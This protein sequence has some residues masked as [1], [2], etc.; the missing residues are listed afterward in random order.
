MSRNRLLTIVL[1]ASSFAFL[2]RDVIVKLVHDWGIDENYSHGFLVVPLVVYIL[3]R[4][5]DHLA[6]SPTRPSMAG[7]VLIAGSVAMLV[8]GRLGAELYLTRLAML[9]TLAGIVVLLWGFGRLRQLSFEFLLLFLAIPI[10]A[11]IFNQI[12]FPLQLV[13]SRFGETAIAAC[14]IP[15]LR[16]GN[17][18]ILATTTLEVAEACSGIR[19][20]V[21]LLTLA[22]VWGYLSGSA[23]WLRWVLAISSVPIAIFSNAIRVAG[24]GIASHFVGPEAAEGFLHTFSG[25]MVFVVA[26]VLMLTVHRLAIW[27]APRKA[28]ADPPV[29]EAVSAGGAPAEDGERGLLARGLVAAAVLGAAALSLAAMTRTEVTGPSEPLSALPLSLG[30]WQG[31]DLPKFDA[32]VLETLG[33]DEYLNRAY[34]QPGGPGVGSVHRVLQDPASGT[35][36]AQPPQLPAGSRLGANQ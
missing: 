9:G 8:A 1:V 23:T 27:L 11:I 20:L 33:V 22:L 7:L 26:G 25:W 4:E 15:V 6:S 19:S 24:T 31:R 32:R 17:V 3:W 2:F 35:D 12:A 29:T 18:I 21:S 30:D 10:P 14:G 28:L 36:D 16:E 13:A 34:G 5:R